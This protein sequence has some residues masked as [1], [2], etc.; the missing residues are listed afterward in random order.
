MTPEQY[1]NATAFTR[2]RY[3]FM[4]SLWG[5]P[6]F[7]LV[8]IWLPDM[9]L[10]FLKQGAAMTTRAWFDLAVVYVWLAAFLGAT[11][12]LSMMLSGTSL[13]A[14]MLDAFLFAFLI[15][16]LVWNTFISF[17]SI[18]QHTSPGVRWIQPTG[19]P[20]TVEQAMAGTVHVVLPEYLDRLFHRIMQHQAH[21][22][23]V[24]I[25]LQELKAAQSGVAEANEGR[26]VIVW[27]PA[28]HLAITRACKL[29]DVNRQRWCTFAE[30]YETEP[31]MELAA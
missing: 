14:A 9:W 28:Y 13:P 15:P 2:A 25:P 24:G 12:W 19:A 3:R 7:Y 1:R 20:S 27:T 29:Y 6:F 22:V 4:R 10:P 21:H 26:L 31:S 17:L 5:Q 23:H 8:E 30:A 11:T 18:V 16:F